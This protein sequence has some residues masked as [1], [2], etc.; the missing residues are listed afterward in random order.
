MQESRVYLF[1]TATDQLMEASLLDEVIDRHLT[2]WSGS[3]SAAMQA[4]CAG[5][6][7]RDKPE[8]HHWDWKWKVGE[9]RPMLGYHS[10]AITCEVESGLDARE[11]FEIGTHSGPVWQAH[12][13]CG[14]CGDR[15]LEPA[16]NSDAAALS[17]RG[18]GHGDSGG[19]IELGTRLPWANW[20]SFPAGGREV[21]PGHVQ[22]E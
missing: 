9:W 5:R 10:F 4:H 20:T 11:R 22:Y 13:V 19:G 3:W 18:N 21:L 12:R 16:R 7:L 2:M 17:R 14:V 8:D 1:K 15:A 6:V